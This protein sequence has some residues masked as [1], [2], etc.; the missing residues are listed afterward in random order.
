MSKTRAVLHYLRYVITEIAIVLALVLGTIA[1]LTFFVLAAHEVAYSDTIA[2]RGRLASGPTENSMRAFHDAVRRGADILETDVRQS[3]DGKLA[4][5]HDRSIRRTTNGWGYVDRRTWKQLQGA[6]VNGG[7]KI[8]SVYDFSTVLRQYKVAG[9]LDIKVNLTAEGW[10]RM[11]DQLK[12]T[13]VIVYSSTNNAYAREGRSWFRY[14]AWR[15]SSPHL[16]YKGGL[17]A[18]WNWA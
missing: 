18:D 16:G 15:D 3:K 9:L 7:G 8:P 11:R 10:R 14:V 12:G 17:P 13:E 1:A 4:L 6:T 5:M 2:H